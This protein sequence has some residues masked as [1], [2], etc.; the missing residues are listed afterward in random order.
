MDE[1]LTL[2]ARDLLSAHIRADGTVY[3]PVSLVQRHFQLGYLDA[4][5]IVHYI[6]QE[7]FIRNP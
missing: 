2:R 4:L 1:C 6:Q 3:N 5:E 7:G